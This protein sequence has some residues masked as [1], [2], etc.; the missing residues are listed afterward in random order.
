ELPY[1]LP[2]D[3]TIFLILGHKDNSVWKRKLQ[4]IA[5]KGG[6]AL[7]NTHPDYMRFDDHKAT[8]LTYDVRLY[9]EFLNFVRCEFGE[10]FWHVLP[11]ELA[12]YMASF[13]P[14]VSSDPY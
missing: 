14:N 6:M 9:W 13:L 12:R 3:H 5:K 8:E 7:L 11:K 2:Q 4:W 10:D 1:T